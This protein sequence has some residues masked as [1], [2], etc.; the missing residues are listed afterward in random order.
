MG[1]LVQDEAFDEWNHPKDKRKNYR[2]Q[3]AEDETCGYTESF[4]EWG[5]ADVKAMVLRDRNHPCVVIWSIG[6]EID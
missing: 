5:E 4:A 2:Q 1:F 6:N 3:I